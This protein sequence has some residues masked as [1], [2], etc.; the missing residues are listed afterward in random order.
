MHPQAVYADKDATPPSSSIWDRLWLNDQQRAKK[1]FDQQ[2]FDDAE[3]LFD[4]SDHQWQGSA[5]YKNKNYQAAV[6]A[7]AQGD[8]ATDDY[9]RGNALS[10]LQQ[11][12][13]AIAAYDSA[14]V[15]DPS[16]I[17]AKKNR[18]LV[19]QLQAQ[20]QQQNSDGDDSE[21]NNSDEKQAD[22]SSSQQA[23]GSSQEADG[24]SQQADGSSQKETENTSAEQQAKSD[25][26]TEHQSA[27][28]QDN[29]QND[30]ENNN[31]DVRNA[32]KSENENSD[33]ENGNHTQAITAFD[34]LSRE[35]QQELEQWIQKIPDDPSGLLRRKFEYEFEKRREL[36]RSG[37]W[38]LP[39]NNAHERY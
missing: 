1:A 10:Q 14:L 36:Y 24:S 9:N 12:D 23:D 29:Q 25:D 32:K 35:E 20:Q 6:E 34:Q 31:A 11:F 33:G 38:Q 22:D 26:D 2:Q 7:F 5:A 8:S 18:E 19:Q 3:Q 13:E 15:K 37:K 21:K 17:D 27:L 4:E 28:E 39:D 16:L 30:E